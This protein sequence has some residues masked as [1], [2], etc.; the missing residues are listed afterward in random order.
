MDSF[1]SRAHKWKVIS[2]YFFTQFFF[3]RY[4]MTTVQVIFTS[5]YKSSDVTVEM[6]V[7]HLTLWSKLQSQIPLN[8]AIYGVQIPRQQSCDAFAQ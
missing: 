3:P 4:P 2:Q 5:S 6:Q 7:T 1:A 8:C